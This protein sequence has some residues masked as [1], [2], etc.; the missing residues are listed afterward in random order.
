MDTSEKIK[1]MQQS[2]GTTGQQFKTLKKDGSLIE[3]IDKTILTEDNR[4]MLFG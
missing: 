3:R 4:E 1:L 2:L